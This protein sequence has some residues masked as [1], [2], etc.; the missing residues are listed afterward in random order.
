KG[1]DEVNF[2]DGQ[3]IK[4]SRTGKEFTIATADDVSFNKV[5]AADSVLVGTGTNL[6]TLDGTTGSVTGNI[7]KAGSVNV[8][9][10]NNTVTGLSNTTW[11]GTPVSGRAA[12]ED[13][14]KTIADRVANAGW[15]ATSGIT[16][17]GTQSGTQSVT[18]VG[19]GDT[20]TFNAGDNLDMNQ[21]GAAFTY[22]LKP[23]LTGLTSAAFTDGTN[24]TTV[25]GSGV[26]AGGVSLTNSGINAGNKVISNVASGG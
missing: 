10:A 23:T 22:S 19:S 7:F 21:S 6:I 18:S 25:N 26:T 24:T 5:T 20:V 13:Q 16:G 1:G 9:G 15:K 4:I 17:S 11:S 14:L 3:N 2:K 8:N 12:T